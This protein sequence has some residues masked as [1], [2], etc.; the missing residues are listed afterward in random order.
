MRKQFA[1][2]GLGRFGKSL[3]KTLSTLGHDVLAVDCHESRVQSVVNDVTHAVQA[4][5]REE[6]TLKA[7]GIRNFDVA[8]VAIGNDIEANILITVMLKD[9]GIKCVISKAQNPLHGR[10]L[11]RIGADKVIYPEKDMGIRLAHS[12]VTSSI[13]DY[14]ELSSDY[15]IVEIVTPNSF[16]GKTIGGLNLRAKFG[17]SVLAVKRGK[18]I[19][20]APGAEAV[21]KEKDNLVI[22]SKNEALSKLPA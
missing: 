18:S 19:I 11:E 17:I 8:I 21:I 2:I 9:L 1:V 13:M 7:V 10:V 22:L 6:D 16:V 15:S 3:A 20:V 12:L 4:D 5:A 14:I